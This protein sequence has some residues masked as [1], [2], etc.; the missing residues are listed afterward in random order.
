MNRRRFWRSLLGLAGITV[1]ITAANSKRS[2]EALFRYGDR[3]VP[4]PGFRVCSQAWTMHP[5]GS[6]VGTITFAEA[7]PNL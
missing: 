5:D 1:G 6:T 2:P 4:P 7:K 3:F